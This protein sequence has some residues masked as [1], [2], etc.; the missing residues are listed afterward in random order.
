MDKEKELKRLKS[1]L[2]VKL[3]EHK[4]LTNTLH[5]AFRRDDTSAGTLR[6]IK[7]AIEDTLNDIASLREE[8]ENGCIYTTYKSNLFDQ[9]KKENK[10]PI[11]VLSGC[12]SK[13]NYKKPYSIKTFDEIVKDKNGNEREV[14]HITSIE[15]VKTDD[16]LFCN[17]FLCDLGVIGVPETMVKWVCP[18][19]T[20]IE[21]YV[22]VQIYDF[23]DDNGTPILAKL[24]AYNGRKFTFE[25]K[26]LDP[27]GCVVYKEKYNGCAVINEFWRDSLAYDRSEP[28]TIRFRIAYDG[29]SYE[30]GC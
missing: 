28:S 15:D 12:E 26:H 19:A 10:E 14:C 13:Y 23:T 25:I 29:V 8:I 16:I 21:R 24:N 27:T 17:R 2:E 22:E 9:I 6:D 18:Y 1:N 30:T 5:E 7:R 4:M 11:S 20:T 3:N